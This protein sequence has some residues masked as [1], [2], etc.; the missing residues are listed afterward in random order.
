MS[1]SDQTRAEHKSS[2]ATV[3]DK[4]A[5]EETAFGRRR[6]G[7]MPKPLKSLIWLAGVPL[8]FIYRRI[9]RSRQDS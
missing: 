5:Y 4:G 3:G 1:K 9:R 2:R 8:L 6:I 7:K